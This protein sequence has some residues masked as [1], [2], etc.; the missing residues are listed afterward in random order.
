MTRGAAYVALFA[1]LPVVAMA[2]RCFLLQ[3]MVDY[4]QVGYLRPTPVEIYSG[5]DHCDVSHDELGAK[6]YLCRWTFPYRA[7]VATRVFEDMDRDIGQCFENAV[8]LPADKIVNHPDS[9]DLR[10]YRIE[11]M[12]IAVSLKDKAALDRTLMFLRLDRE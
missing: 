12:M 8:A 5:A 9:Y 1:C 6:T 3:Q 10:R 11:N 2:D 4:A 7:S